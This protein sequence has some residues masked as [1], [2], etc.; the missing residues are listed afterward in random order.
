MISPTIA[1]SFFLFIAAYGLSWRV[2]VEMLDGTNV[3]VFALRKFRC[4]TAPKGS[5]TVL[6]MT[7]LSRLESSHDLSYSLIN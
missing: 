6:P 5:R 7:A 2:V 3:A 1:K 4:T